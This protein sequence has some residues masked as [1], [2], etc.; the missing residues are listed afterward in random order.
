VSIVLKAVAM[1]MGVVSIILGILDVAEV[2]TQVTML[3]IET[4]TPALAAHL[5]E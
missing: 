4:A 2:G 3:S 5:K 1:A